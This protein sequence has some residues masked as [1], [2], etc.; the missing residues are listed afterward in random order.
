MITSGLLK[1]RLK[2]GMRV[3]LNKIWVVSLVPLFLLASCATTPVATK[4][5]RKPTQ[6]TPQ[7]PELQRSE[8]ALELQ[9]SAAG[10]N[11]GNLEGFLGIYAENAT[12]AAQDRLIRGKMG[13]R[14]LYAPVFKPGTTHDSLG[15]EQL[16]V[17][18]LSPDLAL[19]KGVYKNTR[20]GVVT[21]RG[22]TTLLFQRL[23]GRWRIVHDHSS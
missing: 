12:F 8:I 17:D 3:L 16:E 1:T 11:M 13:I 7:T 22:T 2:T 6:P 14:D 23:D 5:T 15:F 20:N 9:K 21:R 18:I 4:T 19:A 10:W